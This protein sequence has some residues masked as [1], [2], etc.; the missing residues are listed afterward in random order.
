MTKN[1][2][3]IINAGDTLDFEY[4]IL[5][6]L[7]NVREHT[8]Y[9]CII[10]FIL[11][12]YAFVR[13]PEKNKQFW[14]IIFIGAVASLVAVTISQ[15]GSIIIEFHN[16]VFEKVK[17]VYYILFINETFFA[18]RNITLPIVNLI[19]VTPLLSQRRQT[20]LKY[21]VYVMSL[22]QFIHRYYIGYVRIQENC[23]T[24][25]NTRVVM[26]HGFS[27][28]NLSITDFVCCA[29]IIKK[30]AN[31]YAVASK[32]NPETSI[33][34]YYFESALFLVIFVDLACILI[35]ILAIFNSQFLK[36]MFVT[37]HGLSSNIILLLAFDTLIFS[38]DV[39]AEVKEDLE[40]KS[41]DL[42][43]TTSLTTTTSSSFPKHNNQIIIYDKNESGGGSD[44]ALDT[45]SLKR[46]NPYASAGE[47]HVKFNEMNFYDPTPGMG[48]G[49]SSGSSGGGG[50]IGVMGGL[51][52]VHSLN[53]N[54]NLNQRTS[55]LISNNP[56]S[57]Q[58]QQQN[59][60]VKSYPSNIIPI[61]E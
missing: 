22:G 14:N 10:Q 8:Y 34:K 5:N 19:K 37:F 45:G 42:E 43:T 17:T 47:K 2:Y 16:N 61:N 1:D 48:G 36:I 18:I 13:R 53:L 26:A 25:D 50:G 49:I 24:M 44:Y 6:L 60:K 35:S 41:Y 46:L 32:K 29:V 51:G 59:E 28:I 3:Y 54:L 12:A 31:D 55:T 39:K 27:I 21:F 57:P 30:L 33:Y 11:I 52:G 58:Q 40:N 4:V 56:L 20:Y 9:A 7:N 38:N 15:I 23:Y